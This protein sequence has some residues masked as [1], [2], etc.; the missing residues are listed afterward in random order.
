MNSRSADILTLAALFLVFGPALRAQEPEYETV[1]DADRALAERA[2]QVLRDVQETP[3]HEQANFFR[4]AP[5]D[6][7]LKQLKGEKPAAPGELDWPR[8]DIRNIIRIAEQ[9][10][11][12]PRPPNARVP[13]AGTPITLD[14]RLD[15]PAWR[16]ALT[17]TN[18][19]E[20][21]TR[22][23]DPDCRTT[24]KLLWDEQY[25]YVAYDCRDPDLVA[26]KRE[27]DEAVYSDDC[28]EIFL[29]PDFRFLTYWEIIV[30]PAGSLYDALQCK[31]YEE[32]G[33]TSRKQED[34]E[35]LGVGIGLRGTLN[36]PEDED[37][38][39]TIELAVPFAELPGYTRCR[40]VAGQ[41]LHFMLCR[42]DK[43]AGRLKAYAYQPLLSWGHN[44]WNHAVMELVK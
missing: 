14:G 32:W 7:W 2:E 27:R 35:G 20:F 31:K 26:E 5:R 29:L 4:T 44:I 36:E 37:R 19:Y 33:C 40:P 22:D 1:T 10:P 16:S 12:W 3:G 34:V 28:V 23:N 17:Y 25:L 41:T 11:D 13:Y 42:L 9:G 43:R 30:S 15:D 39:Y 38:G 8:Q 6:E 18:T 21:N 24:W